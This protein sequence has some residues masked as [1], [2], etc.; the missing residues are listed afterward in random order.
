MTIMNITNRLCCIDI[1]DDDNDYD[2]NW[3][4]EIYN[5]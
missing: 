5:D 3:E 4:D 1:Y 2:E